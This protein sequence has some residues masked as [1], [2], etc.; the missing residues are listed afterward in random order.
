MRGPIPRW[1]IEQGKEASKYFR[2]DFLFESL[3]G[4]DDDSLVDILFPRPCSLS[5]RLFTSDAQLVPFLEHLLNVD[6]VQ[7]PTAKEALEHPWLA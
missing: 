4:N 1:M 6:F 2:D 3:G 7:R 5:H